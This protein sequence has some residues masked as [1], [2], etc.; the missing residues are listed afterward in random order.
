MSATLKSLLLIILL[1]C[2]SACRL[3][4]Q[5]Y[6]QMV[7]R[8]LS[9]A[10]HDS[11]AEAESFFRQA[12]KAYPDDYRNSLLFTNL[13]KVQEARYWQNTHD[14]KKAD[15]AI[16]SYS[17][18]LALA[19]TS[20]PML[21]ARGQFYLKLEMWRKAIR[22]FSN[23]LDVNPHNLAVRNLRAF[24]Y[25]KTRAYDEAKT[26]YLRV[27]DEEAQNYS[28]RLGLAILEQLM[29][30]LS[31]AIERIS[32]MITTMPDKAEL[33]SVRA[34]MYAENKQPE[35]AIFDLDKAISLDAANVNYVLARA[36]LHKERGAKH[37]ALQ[38]FERAIRLG[39]P[40]ASLNEEIK[41]CK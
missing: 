6:E 41:A 17:M 28:A 37:A 8:G 20:V 7:E 14:K 21:E 9:A 31:V 30:H 40:A 39:I 4:A 15:E 1:W 32:T 23:I 22:D 2:A 11:L 10:Q 16:E 33:Y 35:L 34:G 29:G 36:Y 19:P 27:L 18:A 26:D 3:R 24:A 25:A 13:G 38:D 12:L 5:T